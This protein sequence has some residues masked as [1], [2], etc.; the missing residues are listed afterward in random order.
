MKIS[1]FKNYTEWQENATK[2]KWDNQVD[3]WY[4]E[5]KDILEKN[6]GSLG[7]GPSLLSDRLKAGS[8][9]LAKMNLN[10]AACSYAHGNLSLDDFLALEKAIKKMLPLDWQSE[11]FEIIKIISEEAFNAYHD[12]HYNT[13]IE[14][15]ATQLVHNAIESAQS[16]MALIAK[17][18]NLES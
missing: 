7:I 9:M 18:S 17:N 5:N 12:Y 10:M 6:T 4:E 11:P 16:E 15:V 3:S 8:F 14:G 2:V 13:A 1:K